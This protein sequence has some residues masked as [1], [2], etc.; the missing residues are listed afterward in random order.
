MPLHD[1]VASVA[2]LA[3][4]LLGGVDD[5]RENTVIRTATLRLILEQLIDLSTPLQNGKFA[6]AQAKTVAG[7]LAAL[8]G[9]VD[10]RR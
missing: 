6:D 2:A 7:S 3:R 1:Q 10:G 5:S 4:N 8:T 9:V